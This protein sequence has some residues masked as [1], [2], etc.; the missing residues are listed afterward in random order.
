M[1]CSKDIL[2]GQVGS[3][4]IL[5]MKTI[6]ERVKAIILRPKETWLVIKTES[7][8]VQEL[9]VNY[10]APLA[11]IP[12]V[13]SFIGLAI[14]GVRMPIGVVARAPFL[15]ALVGSV[16]SYIFQLLSLLA[17]AWVV[18]LLAQYF[19]AQS[20]FL[21]AFKVVVFSMTPIWVLGIL[22]IFPGLGVLQIFGLYGVYLLYLGL[23]LVLETPPEKL[24]LYTIL[25]IVAS[26]F[27]SI[28]MSIL[29]GGAVYGPMFMRMM[30]V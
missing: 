18:N 7:G 14:V 4:M 1:N 9:I 16:V 27:I 8:T 11:L 10:A 19:S 28:V 26:L 22:S 17:A 29:V 15:E 21:K 25:V 3:D 13:A 30:S 2:S 12:A 23:Q 5:A 6:Y 20:D 24:L